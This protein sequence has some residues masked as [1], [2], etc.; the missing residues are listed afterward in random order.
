M[1]SQSVPSPIG[2]GAFKIGRNLKTKYAAPY[3]LP[4]DEDAGTLLNGVL[5]L[6]ITLIDTAPAYGL[7]EE[8]IGRHL[9]DR[10]G[11]FVLSTKV[12]ETFTGG[13]SNYAFDRQSV[14]ASIDRS[15]G[16]LQTDHLDLLFIHSAGNDL[17]LLEST[18]VLETLLDR[19]TAGDIGRI[20]F[21]GKTN[22][23]ASAALA[24]GAIDALMVAFSPDDRASA[25]VLD[26]A[27]KLGVDVFV[28]K[29]LGS[30]RVSA[31]EAIP[32]CL[33]H[34]SVRTL[35]IG[36]LS[37]EHM[38]ANCRIAEATRPS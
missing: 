37:L 7:S 11:E 29:G 26:A 9:N 28:K 36:S 1:K 3:D 14:S 18:D 22:D 15:L 17:A 38:A 21:S 16:A 19:K 27:A 8:R 23:G 5:D 25:D 35:V 20:G 30:G 4:S 34:P 2:F 10:R 32:F 12:G 13:E 31:D 24:T 6:G 33:A